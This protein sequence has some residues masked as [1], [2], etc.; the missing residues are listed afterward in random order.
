MAGTTSRG[1]RYPGNADTP[2]VAAD[3]QNLA[4]D[5]NGDVNTHITGTAVHGV[6]GAVVGTTDVQ[7]LTNKNLTAATNTFPTSLATLTGAQALTNKDLT[8]G[9]N[10]FPSSFVTLS[11]SQTLTSKKFVSPMEISTISTT[12]ASA[13]STV[14]IDVLTSSILYNKTAATGSFTLVVRGNSGT[15]LASLMNAGDALTV[16]FLNTTG[17]TPY[18]FTTFR[19][20]S[21]SITPKWQNGLTPGAGNAN[22]IDAYTFTII[23]TTDATPWVAL[24]SISKYS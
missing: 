11:G 8:S 18:S 17:S 1:Y 9:T 7:A 19:I 5:V 3:I 12:A 10:T 20:D 6:T 15:T 2:N 23:K 22:A 16:V 24:A 13:G 14:N 4:T 21:T